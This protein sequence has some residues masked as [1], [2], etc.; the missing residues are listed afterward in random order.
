MLVADGQYLGFD[1]DSLNGDVQNPITIQAQGSNAVVNITTDR[2][3]NRDTIFVTFSS[4]VVI[5]GLRSTNAN[6]AAMRIDQSPNITARNCV[7]GNNLTW[8]IFTDFSDDLLLEGN[9]CFGSV[10]QHGIYV[11]NT[12]TR[13]VVR[14]NRLHDNHDNGLHMNGDVSQGGVGLITDA[15]VENNIIYNNGLNNGGGSGINCDGVQNSVFR[16]NLIYAAHGAGITLYQT[17]ASA[18]SINATVINNTIDVASDGK[19]AIQIHSGSSGAVVFNNIFLTHHSFHGSIHLTVPADRQGLVC[20][21]NILTTNS[22]VTTLDNDNS[23]LTFAQ[24]QA[25]GFDTHSAQATQDA[26]FLNWPNADYHLKAGSPAVNAGAASLG[27]KTPPATDI[28]GT[29]RP[30]DNSFD[31]GAYE[32]VSGLPPPP[33]VLNSNPS[34]TANPTAVNQMVSFSASASGGTGGLTYAWDFGD[35]TTGSGAATTHTYAA[36][37]IFNAVVTVTDT[38]NATTTGNVS[39]TVTAIAIVGDGPDSDGDGFSDAFENAVGTQAGSASS[40][41]TGQP[42]TAQTLQ[43]LTISKASI[44][45]NFAAGGKDAITFAG[46]LSVPAGFNSNGAKVYFDTSGVAKVLTLTAKGSAKMGGDAVTIAIKTKKGAVAAQTAKYTVKFS[47]GSFAAT[48]AAQD[49]T[50]RTVS[51]AP[52]MVTFTFIFNSIVYQ[53]KLAMNYTAKSGKSGTAQ[54]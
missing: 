49:L 39:V 52:V 37:G 6:R 54:P 9:E 4:Y 53:K 44:K 21:Y 41:P 11:S 3:D 27:G 10:Q 26:C 5:D 18:P 14:G 22:N 45:L 35:S 28:E 38:V 24:W 12:C 50:N 40:T 51:K 47:S 42:V 34:A 13:P 33:L 1:V 32:F 8:G 36:P 48:L 15:L 19:W 7:F 43:M 16:N 31:L 30:L 23:D 17:D 46:M 25:L 29:A 20:D 2:E